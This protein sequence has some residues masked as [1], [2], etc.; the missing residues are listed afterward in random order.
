MSDGLITYE[1]FAK[2][3][4]R[5]GTVRSAERVEGSNKLLKLLVDLGEEFPR[6]ILAGIGK[7]YLPNELV[8]TQIIVIANLEP[9]MLMGIESQGMLLAAGDGTPTLLRPATL[10]EPG[11]NIH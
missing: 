11:S 10:V 3:D 1:E 8:D 7:A 5:V 9:R 4:L 6:Q 2:L